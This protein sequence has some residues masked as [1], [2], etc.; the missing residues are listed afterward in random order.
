MTNLTTAT[1]DALAEVME[2]GRWVGQKKEV[3]NHVQE[4][5]QPTEFGDRH[6]EY[7]D[8]LNEHHNDDEHFSTVASWTFPADLRTGL[9]GSPTVSNETGKY[10]E[11][12]VDSPKGNQLE[13]MVDKIDNWGRNNRTVAQVFQVANDLNSMFPPCL[14]DISALYRD[15]K[16]HLTAHYRSH[17]VAKSY[18]GD[19]VGL[20]RLQQWLANEIKQEAEVGKMTVLS[21][22]LHIRKKNNEHKLAEEMYN[23]FR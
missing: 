22:S 3:L 1:T 12:L 20:S 13:S 2:N 14:L 15:E 4:V 5:T 23:H 11:K 8:M 21:N 16:I 10:F 17:T 19:I 9:T 6:R 18:Y 7:V